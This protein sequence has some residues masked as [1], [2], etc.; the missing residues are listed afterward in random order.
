MSLSLSPEINSASL[1]RDLSSST[2]SP[3]LCAALSLILSMNSSQACFF[4]SP[5]RPISLPQSSYGFFSKHDDDVVESTAS[6][7]DRRNYS[8]YKVLVVEPDIRSENQK[9]KQIHDGSA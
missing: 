6:A 3:W 2:I 9:K 5:L 8:G 4:H 7:F 1:S